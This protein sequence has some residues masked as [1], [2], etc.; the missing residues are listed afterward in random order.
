MSQA[1]ASETR[2]QELAIRALP[3]LCRIADR[4]G[5]ISYTRL[6]EMIGTTERPTHAIAM[7][8]PLTYIW[9]KICIPMGVPE[10]WTI[11]V[12]DNGEPSDAVISLKW[13]TPPVEM[14]RLERRATWRAMVNAVHAYPWHLVMDEMLARLRA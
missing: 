1:V 11:V 2:T 6:A 4:C 7:R 8:F 12:D 10:L 13:N 5:T 3:I 9:Q 14:D